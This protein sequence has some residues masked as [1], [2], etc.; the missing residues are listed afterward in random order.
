MKKLIEVSV[1]FNNTSFVLQYGMRRQSQQSRVV[2][3]HRQ[4]RKKDFNMEQYTTSLRFLFFVFGVFSLLLSSIILG[5]WLLS[6]IK[7][8]RNSSNVKIQ[9]TV[10]VCGLSYIY[11]FCYVPRY[12]FLIYIYISL[13]FSWTKTSFIIQTKKKIITENFLIKFKIKKFTTKN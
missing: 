3:K 13:H 5:L 4:I 12:L 6:Y 10:H 8:I 9:H 7:V 2:K 1:G 11:K